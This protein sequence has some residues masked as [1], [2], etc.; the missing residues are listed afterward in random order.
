MSPSGLAM[1]ESPL[2]IPFTAEASW[3][4]GNGA[5][6]QCVGAQASV[7]HRMEKVGVG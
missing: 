4:L 7:I 1:G 6:K 5:G 3:G 2:L